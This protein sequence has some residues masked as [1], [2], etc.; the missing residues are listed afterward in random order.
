[1]NFCSFL[2]FKSHTFICLKVCDLSFWVWFGLR[3]TTE[4][5]IRRSV[6]YISYRAEH[7]ELHCPCAAFIHRIHRLFYIE[8]FCHIA[9]CQ[10]L[11][12]TQFFYDVGVNSHVNMLPSKIFLLTI[13]TYYDIVWLKYYMRCNNF[14]NF[15]P[16]FKAIS[17]YVVR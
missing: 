7:F 15:A 9:L 6:E 17:A 4:Q 3:S 1:M 8:I 16:V 14:L 13:R 5:I 12:F 10:A 11:V 2:M